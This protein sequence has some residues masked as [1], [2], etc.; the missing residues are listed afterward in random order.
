MFLAIFLVADKVA[1]VIDSVESTTASELSVIPLANPIATYLPIS[2]ITLEGD[3]TLSVLAATV[4]TVDTSFDV[5]L[6]TLLVE[7][8]LEIPFANPLEAL[9]P[10]LDIADDNLDCA[11]AA[12]ANALAAAEANDEAAATTLSLAEFIPLTIP[13]HI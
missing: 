9:D 7:L 11:D 6:E 13:A 1:L 10:I 8:E 4:G 5:E 12:V 3:L 2:I